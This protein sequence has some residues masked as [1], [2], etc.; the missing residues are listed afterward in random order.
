M[1][2]SHLISESQADL[3]FIIQLF[4]YAYKDSL[5]IK[6]A[7]EEIRFPYSFFEIL[8]CL[9]GHDVRPVQ[10][11]ILAVKRMHMSRCIKRNY[12]SLY[13]IKCSME[14]F[15]AVSVKIMVFWDVMPCTLVGQKGKAIPVTGRGGP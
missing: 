6:V 11:Q 13:S 7:I 12:F 10:I 15:T 14:N 1:K 4:I 2:T 3:I 5:N 9:V 8:L